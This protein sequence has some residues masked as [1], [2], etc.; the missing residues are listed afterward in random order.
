VS[1]CVAVALSFAEPLKGKGSLLISLSPICFQTLLYKMLRN[2]HHTQ[3]SQIYIN[4]SG[5]ASN[6]TDDYPYS[7]SVPAYH[8]STEK[9][10][11]APVSKK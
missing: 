7:W 3:M 5:K 9:F 8:P 10:K 2:L 1:G 11:N 4:I 6:F